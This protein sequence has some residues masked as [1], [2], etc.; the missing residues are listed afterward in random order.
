MPLYLLP[1]QA[2][3]AL[4]A[5]EIR[6]ED[7]GRTWVIRTVVCTCGGGPAGDHSSRCPMF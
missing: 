5:G 7:Y 3:D 4:A 1:L 6:W 2:R